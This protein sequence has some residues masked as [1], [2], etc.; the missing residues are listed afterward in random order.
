MY[1]VDTLG[2]GTHC[3]LYR[4]C[5]LFGGS[6]CTVKIWSSSFGT[7]KPVLYNYGGFIYCA[8]CVLYTKCPLREV[9]RTCTW[10]SHMYMYVATDW[11]Y[12]IYLI[13]RTLKC[14]LCKEVIFIVSS[15]RR[16][17][18]WRFH[19]LSLQ[20]TGYNFLTISL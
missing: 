14:V 7:I 3:A 6:K 10:M 9:S 8:Y 4:G 20:C 5:P 13:S 15:S 17:L 11:Y 16:V 18:Y 12:C 1:T 19:Y 2:L